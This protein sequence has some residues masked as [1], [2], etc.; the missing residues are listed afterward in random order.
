VR[1]RARST[2]DKLLAELEGSRTVVAGGHFADFTF[3]RI[4]RG[5]AKRQ[6]VVE[7]G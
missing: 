6:W 1:I 5:E 7:K 3:G 2:R 4:M